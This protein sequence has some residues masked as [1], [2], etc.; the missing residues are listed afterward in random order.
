[1]GRPP[2]RRA[3][4]DN[5]PF[6]VPVFVL[7]HHARERLVKDGGTTFTFVTG[8]IEEA[9][10][11]AQAV[12]GDKNVTIVGGAQVVQQA[13]DARLLDEL[14]I[15]LSPVLLGGGI[16]LFDSPGTERID[17]ERTM[18]VGSPQRYPSPLS[19]QEVMRSGRD[20]LPVPCPDRSIAGSAR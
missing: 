15:H 16:R 20:V 13:I 9:L 18:V 1:V 17:L 11:Q 8:G 2:I 7:T 12:A 3:L 14:L 19:I 4:G 6:Q 5:P 10:G